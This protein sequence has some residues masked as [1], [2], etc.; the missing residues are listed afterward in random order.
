MKADYMILMI[1]TNP[2]ANLIAVDKFLGHH[3]Q[4]FLVYTESSN[5]MIG[6]H[7]IK[8]H[9]AK[10]LK[11]RRPNVTIHSYETDKSNPVLIKQ[12]VDT[13]MQEIKNHGQSFQE[14]TIALNYTGGTKTMAAISYDQ[15][16]RHMKEQFKTDEYY[17]IFCYVDGEIGKILYESKEPIK[18]ISTIEMVVD[19]NQIFED[20][21]QVH[22]YELVRTEEMK[23]RDDYAY[24]HDVCVRNMDQP[25]IEIEFDEI[26]VYGYQLTFLR[27]EFQAKKKD[28]IKFKMFQAKDHTEKIG[29]EHA[30]LMFICDY[31]D[32]GKPKSTKIIED[33]LSESQRINLKNRIRVKNE[34]E[35][36]DQEIEN[37]VKG[38]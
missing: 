9:L 27:K 21:I 35:V 22:G 33:E 20:I 8:D 38:L 1:G 12:T 18:A 13:I 6:T 3:A 14:K 25:D 11:K 36:T 7:K 23:L 19:Y 37:L 2:L 28:K 5:G 34:A 32:N 17:F 26:F 4:V 24:F 30:R 16:K 29:G 31:Q 15:I 10:T